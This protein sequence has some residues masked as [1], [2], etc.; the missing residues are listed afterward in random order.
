M[1]NNTSILMGGV[2]GQGIVLASRLLAHVI[3]AHNHELKISEIHGMAQRGGSVITYV[4]FGREVFS[5]LI[6]PGQADYILAAEKLEAWRWLP[7]LRRGGTMVCSTQEI[8]TVPVI[9]GK[10]EYPKT[11][12]EKMQALA[13]EGTIGCLYAVN[14]LEIAEKC[15]QPKAATVALIGILARCLPFPVESYHAALKAVVPARFLEANEKTFL[16]GYNCFA[17]Q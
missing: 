12:M 10:Q 15:G 5:P 9:T 3:Q 16:A 8:K 14:A 7:Y 4:R 11:I 13:E 6:E 17:K 2:G 1:R